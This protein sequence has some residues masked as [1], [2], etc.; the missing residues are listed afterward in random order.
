MK[1]MNVHAGEASKDEWLTPP[2]IIQSLGEFDLDPCSPIN[3]PWPTA[4]HH[5]TILDD[6]LMKEW[7]GRVWMNPPYGK[8][9]EHW[10]NRLA[11]HGDGIAFTFARTE[12]KA[13]QKLVFPHADSIFFLS[14]RVTFY[15]VSGNKAIANGGAPSVLIAY[16][17]RNSDAINDSGLQGCHLPVNRIGITIL[18]FDATWKAVVKTAFI[19]LNR[20]ADLDELYSIVQDIAPE[21]V[22]RNPHFQ[23]KIRQTVQHHFHR[24]RRGT[25]HITPTIQ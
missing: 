14:G 7:F 19:R 8:A 24:V 16:G 6:G 18:G 17:G 15:H 13:F 22:A 20:P 1:K 5:F 10:L 2:E 9:L 4:K 23:A 3:R 11:L 21:K 25:Y 12:T